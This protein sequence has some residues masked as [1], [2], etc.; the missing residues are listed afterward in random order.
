MKAVKIPEREITAQIRSVLKTFGVFHWKV[1]QG[2]GSTPGVPDIVGIFNGKFLGIE[3]KAKN[4]K[5]SPHQQRFLD[6]INANGGIGFVAYSAED[7]MNTLNLREYI[8]GTRGKK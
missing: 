4:G 5:V 7:V 6:N 8:L 3:V 1:W 2:L